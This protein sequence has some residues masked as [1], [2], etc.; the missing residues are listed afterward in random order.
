MRTITFSLAASML[1]ACSRATEPDTAAASATVEASSPVVTTEAGPSRRVLRVCADPNNLPFSNDRHEGF[2]NALASLFAEDL[3]AHLEYTWWAQRRGFFRNT[4]KAGLC[5][6]V[7]GVPAGF[8]LTATTRPIYRSSYVFVRHA[9]AKN[10]RALR[11]FDDGRLRTWRV[12][13]HVIGDDYANS[14]P[15]HALSRRGIV[16]NVV[17]YRLLDDYARDNPPARA[18]DGVAAGEVDVAVVWGPIG[19]YFAKRA[20]R[21]LVV[22]PVHARE[23]DVFPL[24]YA[25]ALGVRRDDRTLRDELDAIV[26]RRTDDIRQLLARFDVPTVE[27]M[28]NVPRPA[29][30]GGAR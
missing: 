19:G 6:V 27:D 5:D 29:R 22:E 16:D 9:T 10:E 17:G 20:S 3:D 25:I 2:E 23:D 21:P 11:S 30:Q 14:P 8:E 13:V 15:V 4:L 26:E 1:L 18:I 24:Q 7:M 28:A 12:G